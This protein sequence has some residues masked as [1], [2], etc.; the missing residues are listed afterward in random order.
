MK[1]SGATILQ[2]SNFAF[3]YCFLHIQGEHKKVAPPTTFVDISAMRRALG[4]PVFARQHP[5]QRTARLIPR[6]AAVRTVHAQ[7]ISCH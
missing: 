4:I 5:V 3:S 7:L 6:A 1:I 2:A